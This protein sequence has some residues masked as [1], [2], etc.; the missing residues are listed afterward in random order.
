MFELKNINLKGI[1][2][3]KITK[4]VAAFAIASTIL[5]SVS[6]CTDESENKNSSSVNESQVSISTS[7]DASKITKGKISEEVL[8][9]LYS[10]NGLMDIIE[11]KYNLD[12]MSVL[13]DKQINALNECAKHLG[14]HLNA[15]D[16]E[17]AKNELDE[18]A[19]SIEKFYDGK[20]PVDVIRGI[21]KQLLPEGS[22]ISVS[23]DNQCL[24]NKK[25]VISPISIIKQ[26]IGAGNFIE[27]YDVDYSMFQLLICQG[28]VYGTGNI[29]N[30]INNIDCL[31]RVCRVYT[32]DKLVEFKANTG[33]SYLGNLEMFKGVNYISG[34]Y[35]A[36][37]NAGMFDQITAVYA[38]D[39]CFNIK[40]GNQKFYNVDDEDLVGELGGVLNMTKGS[41]NKGDIISNKELKMTN[42]IQ[43]VVF[44][45]V[46]D[47]I[48]NEIEKGK[49]KTL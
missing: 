15:T 43:N 37:Y 8:K 3:K 10:L 29:S 14:L 33:Y 17:V 19:E 24:E 7:F 16:E 40:V 32:S 31:I 28:Y 27:N 34:G 26:V 48:I 18:V 45:V 41:I 4:K 30:E 42:L 38:G 39:G 2:G 49:Q 5:C 1:K 12:K 44:S 6:G 25:G 23:K 20:R 9:D 47:D 46:A 35:E 11:G 13:S 22:N 21:L 36:M